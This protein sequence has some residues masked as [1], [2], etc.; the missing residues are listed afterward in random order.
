MRAGG[1][2]GRGGGAGQPARQRPDRR[3]AVHQLVA[4]RLRDR[5]GG[6]SPIEAAIVFP[7]LV[8]M[9]MLV[10]QLALLWHGRNVAEAAAQDGLRSARGY[11]S[12]AALGQRDAEDYLRQV[13]PNLLPAPQVSVERTDTTVTVRVRAAVL[14]I[15]PLGLAVDETAAGPVERFVGPGR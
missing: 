7:V 13:A 11:Q 5:D 15:V 3:R 14:S 2:A 12:T 9:V 1:R 4:R 6:F 10:V 8:F